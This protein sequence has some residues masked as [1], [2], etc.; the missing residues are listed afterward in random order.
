[1]H[2]RG[3]VVY[4]QL[5]RGEEADLMILLKH[6]DA[7]SRGCYSEIIYACQRYAVELV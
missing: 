3:I 7:A 2:R 5:Q 1:L 4:Q 6:L